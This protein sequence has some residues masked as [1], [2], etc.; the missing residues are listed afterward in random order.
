MIPLLIAL[1]IC[2]ALLVYY[3]FKFRAIPV[4]LLVFIFI[5]TISGGIFALKPQIY[6]RYTLLNLG[7]IFC[8]IAFLFAYI[9]LLRNE[10]KLFDKYIGWGDILLLATLTAAF[11][12]VNY[13]AF[14]LIASAL[15][16]IGWSIA[17]LVQRNR[18]PIPFA[19]FIAFFYFAEL[20]IQQFTGLDNYNDTLL[21]NIL[22]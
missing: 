4:L 5:L 8:I 10:K 7:F 14:F 17:M 11:S 1:C 19:G 13:M 18:K 3:D 12:P 6:I 2:L 16:L 21:L 20:L 22:M 9:Y 15:T